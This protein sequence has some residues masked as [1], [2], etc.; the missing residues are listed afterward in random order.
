MR[1]LELWIVAVAVVVLSAAGAA[2]GAEGEMFPF[3]V[4][5]LD[6]NDDATDMSWM[7]DCPAG[8]SG[9]VQVKDGHF[10]DGAGK[11][12]RFLGV[13]VCYATAFPTHAEADVL[14]AR[15]AKLGFNCVRLHHMDGL[16]APMGIWDPAYKDYQHMDAGQL[17]K[18]DYFIAQL[19]K[20]GIY[21][22]MNLHVSRQF[23]KADGFPDA[24]KLTKYCKGVDNFEPRM[25]ELQK[26]YARELL[27]HLNPYTKTRYADEPAVAIIE[28]NNENSLLEYCIDGTI[29]T[30]PELLPLA[31]ARDVERLA[32]EALLIDG[33]AAEGVGR[34]V[35]ADRRQYPDELGLRL[36]DGSLAVGS[37]ESGEGLD[38]GGGRRAGT[39]REMHARRADA[40]RKP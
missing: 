35:G 19:K 30:L 26:V 16:R 20:H 13:N 27:T 37:A 9:F 21:V 22:D 32:P 11:R 14:A 10:A 33:R 38:Q 24:D 39:G 5:T 28:I 31:V 17:D 40:R 34:R 29:D 8:K 2:G 25:I 6:V 18:L 15:L 12:V 1:G 23:T 36:G 7:N 4:Q 3:S